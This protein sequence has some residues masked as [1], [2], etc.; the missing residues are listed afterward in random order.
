MIQ[1]IDQIFISNESSE[2]EGNSFGQEANDVIVTL[3]NG[4]K[5][6]ASFFPFDSLDHLRQ[7]NMKNG[8][9]LNGTYFWSKRM[10]LV[11]DCSRRTI[12]QVIWN[13]LEEGELQEA[14]LKL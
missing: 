8:E 7:R 1:I 3:K 4:E 5:F 2:Q 12:E 9:F 6:H 11:K 10:I 13:L 14:F